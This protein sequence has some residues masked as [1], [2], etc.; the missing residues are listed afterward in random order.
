[1]YIPPYSLRFAGFHSMFPW[2]IGEDACAKIRKKIIGCMVFPYGKCF[3]T[4]EKGDCF[5]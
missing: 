4:A 3:L 5:Y 1:M 2:A